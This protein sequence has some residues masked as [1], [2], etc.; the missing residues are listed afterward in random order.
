MGNFFKNYFQDVKIRWKLISDSSVEKERRIFA[1]LELFCFPASLLTLFLLLP[2]RIA[3]AQTG[4]FVL[5]S[6]WNHVF[7]I[8]LSAAIGY[9]TNY[10]AIEMLFKPYEKSGKHLF[11]ILSLGYWKQGL[12]PKNKSKIGVELGKQVETKL[13]NPEQLANDLCDM[14]MKLLRDKNII[15]KIKVTVQTLLKNHENKIIEFLVPR[16]EASLCETVSR[17]LTKDKLIEVWDKTV[18]PQLKNEDNR[19]LAARQITESLK[20]RSPE[21]IEVLK[22]ELREI[23]L[24]YLSEKL[25]FGLGAETISNGLVGII[26][27]QDIEVRMCDKLDSESTVELIKA[28]LLTLLNKVEEWANTDVGA[29]KVDAVVNNMKDKI[30]TL[31]RE[32]LQE[33]L[34]ALAGSVLDSESL[35]QWIENELLPGAEPQ[36]E[37][38]IKTTGKT[39]IMEKL[40]IS[41]RIAEAVDK[42][43]VKEFHSMINSIAAQHLGAIQVLGYFLGA[44]VGTA[45]IFVK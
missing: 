39:V 21:L 13:L 22:S 41:R 43:D 26:N 45:Q 42:Q 18:V 19:K 5:V 29:A 17:F 34:P 30:I 14:V 31:I 9:I 40:D 28:E 37:A 15:V 1:G 4:W 36:I 7:D 25:P 3:G 23:V 32:F 6:P 11:S 24:N 12:V 10:I 27:W 33:K 38:F 16:I 44:I 20:R 8:L 35:W 2:L